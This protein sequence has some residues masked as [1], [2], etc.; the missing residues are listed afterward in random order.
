MLLLL[1]RSKCHP[2]AQLNAWASSL[3]FVLK[4][5]LHAVH[6]SS[7]FASS[8]TSSANEGLVDRHCVM[9][10][11]RAQR[12]TVT[13]TLPQL[14]TGRAQSVQRLATGWMVRGSNPG[15]GESFLT[16]TKPALWPTQPP[17]K[18]VPCL[19]LSLSG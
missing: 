17:T 1:L 11:H 5:S 3:V 4:H 8:L 13:N 14:W 15:G 19:S 16:P 12:A 6:F 9:P 7:D 2:L 18:R 10:F